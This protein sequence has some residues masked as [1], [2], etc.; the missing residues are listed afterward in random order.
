MFVLWVQFWEFSAEF[1]S[2]EFLCAE[3]SKIDDADWGVWAKLPDMGLG[4]QGA[5][6]IV[7]GHSDCS[8]LWPR[9]FYVMCCQM[10][11]QVP[12]GGGGPSRHGQFCGRDSSV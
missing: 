9:L 10:A 7:W 12:G 1:L 4:I 3:S 2:A 5:E 8:I 6:Y 11:M